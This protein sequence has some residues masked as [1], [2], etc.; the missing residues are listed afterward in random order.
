MYPLNTIWKCVRENLIA[1]KWR[2]IRSYPCQSS[3]VFLHLGF[4]P[5]CDSQHRWP[6]TSRSPCLEYPPRNL[7]WSH[8]LISLEDH[9]LLIK[10]LYFSI[11]NHWKLV[12]LYKLWSSSLSYDQILAPCN[13]CH[14]PWCVG[15]TSYH[16]ALLI[17]FGCDGIS[18]HDS[19]NEVFH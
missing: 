16:K 15:H 4:P 11:S 12:V 5:H 1:E 8:H 17:M 13:Y 9:Y 6:F 18:D 3:Q 19:G 7:G 2:W 14:H 10:M